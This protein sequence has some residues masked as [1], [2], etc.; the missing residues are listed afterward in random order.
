M[1]QQNE[2]SLRQTLRF[3]TS[4][5]AAR[6]HG[7][8]VRGSAPPGGEAGHHGG[9]GADLAQQAADPL[10]G[11]LPQAADALRG[12]LEEVGHR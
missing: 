12:L 5:A 6:K 4:G 11:L 1:L 10:G 2:P 9:G 8:R 3:P 7:Q